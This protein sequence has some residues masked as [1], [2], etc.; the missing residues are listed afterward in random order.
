MNGWINALFNVLKK[1]EKKSINK[2]SICNNLLNDCSVITLSICLQQ[3]I[4]YKFTYFFYKEL[5]Y[6]ML[7]KMLKYAVRFIEIYKKFTSISILKQ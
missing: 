5:R 7:T 2:F 6:F 1:K 3:Y 4:S